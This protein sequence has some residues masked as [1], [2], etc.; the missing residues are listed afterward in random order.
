[1][2]SRLLNIAR[3]VAAMVLL[4]ALFPCRQA[5]AQYYTIGSD[6]AFVQWNRM[7]SEHFSIVYPNYMDSLAR[8]YLFNFEKNRKLSDEGMG[9]EMVNIPLVL[10]PYTS[11]SNATVVWAPKRVDILSTPE[12]KG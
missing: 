12:F 3:I 4:T 10:H 2:K 11:V 5:Y 6:P 9:V 8:V 1:M 7:K